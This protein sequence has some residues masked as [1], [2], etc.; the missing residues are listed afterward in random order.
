ME[1]R[2]QTRKGQTLGALEAIR[3]RPETGNHGRHSGSGPSER[4]NDGALRRNQE[5]MA[6]LDFWRLI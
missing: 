3:G 1:R 5:V 2:V 4:R 6:G